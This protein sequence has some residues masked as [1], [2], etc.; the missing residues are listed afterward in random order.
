MG[1]DVSLDRFTLRFKDAAL[2]RSFREAEDDKSVRT[3]RFGTLV[4]AL[5]FVFAC[6][7]LAV[8][9]EPLRHLLNW[10]DVWV[11]GVVVTVA[12]VLVYGVTFTRPFQ[13]HPQVALAALCASASGWLASGLRHLEP[14]FVANRGFMFLVLHTFTIY[15]LLRMRLLP[16]LAAGWGSL[17]LYV[18]AMKYWHVIGDMYLVRQVFWLAACNVWGSVICY[19]VE[20]S[21][22]REYASALQ[23]QRERER[24]DG[25]LLN[26]LPAPIAERLKSSRE[27]IA[28]HADPVTVLFADIV[29]FTPLSARKK[30]A[31]LVELLDEVF[32]GFD[33]LAAEHGLE[34]IKTIG[35]AYMA[36]AGL[37]HAQPDH[38]MRAARMA[39]AMVEHVERAAQTAGEPLQV[40]IGM[41]T[42]AVV[43]GVIGRSKFSYD[44]WGDTVNTASRMESSGVPGAVHC[45]QATARHLDGDFAVR[46]R[47]P[48]E[49]KGKGTME[50]FLVL[51]AA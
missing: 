11:S 21:L 40:R 7:S 35:D 18:A 47:G 27:R 45:T 25:L 44:L 41:H 42:G 37:P 12:C 43:A 51:G 15:S 2:E 22:R 38:A 34:K 3:M 48:V 8:I 32:T 14:D 24:A 19:Q 30:P 13:A 4:G 6:L 28:E 49:V 16:A 31:E 33:E 10:A 50:T 36:V 5:L 9:P 46:S 39:L 26:I 17:V 23:V 20:R 1:T 29:G